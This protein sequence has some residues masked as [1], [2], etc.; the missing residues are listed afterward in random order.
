M[1]KL[2][3][4]AG[5]LRGKEFELNEGSNLL[6][7]NDDCDIVIENQGVSK[8]HI[9][10]TVTGEFAYLKDLE[11]SNGTFLNGKLFKSGTVKTGDRIALPDNILQVVHV[12][13]RKI[14][15]KK[16]LTDS[17]TGQTEDDIFKGGEVPNALPEKLLHLFKYRLMNFI[18]GINEEYEWRILLGILIFTFSVLVI[19]VSIFPVL[20][21]TQSVILEETKKRGRHFAEEVAR[22]NKNAL[23]RKN[24]DRIDTAFLNDE[25]EV[26]YELMD[27]EGRIVNPLSKRNTYTNDTFSLRAKEEMEKTGRNT[28]FKNDLGGGVI[29]VAQRIRAINTKTGGSEAVGLIALK[30]SS[31][32]LSNREAKDRVAYMEA[33]AISI[34]LCLVFFGFI[35]FLTLRP[36]EEIRFLTE[37]GMKGKVR[38]VE[39]KYLMNE[40][41][42]LKN[43]INTLLHR[44][45]ELS[46]EGGDEFAE[47]E[48][49]EG[50]VQSLREIMIGSGVPALILNSEKNLMNINTEAEDLCGIRENTSQGMSLLDVS[51]EKGFAATIIELCDNSASNNGMSQDG[52]Y[53][54]GGN[55]HSIFVSSLMGRDSYAKA[56]Y[57]TFIK[58]S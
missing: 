9:N 54:I 29:G 55:D 24:L 7:R 16:K 1:Y 15:I 18:H 28:F 31:E 19:S 34:G 49:D 3:A 30:F 11:S 5:P 10:I 41:N 23:A 40:L 22:I 56:F 2:V 57:I 6:G 4:I 51:R 13:E 44:N 47:V 27:L 37:E 20:R 14:I 26:V 17:E 45:R 58:E 53:E 8:K 35:Y 50:Y 36:I 46:N 39:G 43:S 33:L 42:S 25:K 12:E 52:I 48:S 21:T 32:S 38:N